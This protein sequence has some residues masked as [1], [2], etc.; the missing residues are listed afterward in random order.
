MTPST[1][2]NNHDIAVTISTRFVTL[3]IFKP[4][5]NSSLPSKLGL[6]FLLASGAS[7]CVLNFTTFTIFVDHFFFKCSESTHSSE[8]FK[9]LTVAI[10][11]DAPI[12][13]NVTPTLQTFIHGSTGTL[14]IPF[15]VVN[16]E[17]NI[18]ITLFFENMSKL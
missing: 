13:F 14:L 7:V 1:P 5:E 11:A 12:I 6:L 2:T 4:A 9:T 3:Y 16:V 17:Y 10:K 8:D 15:A 18:L